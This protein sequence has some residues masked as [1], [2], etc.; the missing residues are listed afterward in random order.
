MPDTSELMLSFYMGLSPEV[1]SFLLTKP[2]RNLFTLLSTI[3]KVLL[4]LIWVTAH[5]HSPQSSLLP[6]FASQILILF[7]VIADE[8]DEVTTF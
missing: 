1:Q 7:Q 2:H 6:V 8:K 5:R 3:Q 4:G